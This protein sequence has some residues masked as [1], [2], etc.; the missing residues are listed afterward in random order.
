[1]TIGQKVCKLRE[2]RGYSQHYMGL[3]LGISQTAYSKLERG[4]TAISPRRLAHLAQILE[5]EVSNLLDF[6]CQRV[7]QSTAPEGAALTD[8]ERQQ[9]ERTIG[10]LQE[11][12]RFLMSNSVG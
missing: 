9:Y 2:L 12:I 7:F 4:T 5:V 10:Q 11:Q 6:D 3:R 1:M 8:P